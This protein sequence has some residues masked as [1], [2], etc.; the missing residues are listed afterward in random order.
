MNKR[1]ARN[2]MT[3]KYGITGFVDL[4]G[5]VAKKYSLFDETYWL[6]E[7]AILLY[8]W[9]HK[10]SNIIKYDSCAF[11]K[12][13]RPG[14]EI[15]DFYFE[16]VFKKYKYTLSEFK[17]Y[18]DHTIIQILLDLLSAIA[19]LHENKITHRDVKPSN[20][21]IRVD[22]SGATRAILIDFSHAHRMVC[23]LKRIDADV[24]TYPYRA[25]EVFMY[26]RSEKNGMYDEKIDI[27][28]IGMLLIE[29]ITDRTLYTTVTDGEESSW[30]K[31]VT[32]DDYL[33]ILE[34][35]FM[36]N[37]RTFFHADEYWKW[38][39]KMLTKDPAKRISAREMYNEIIE[40]AI[41]NNIKHIIPVNEKYKQEEKE[42]DDKEG[43]E[44]RRGSLTSLV[45][46]KFMKEIHDFER[47]AK[48]AFYFKADTVRFDDVMQCLIRKKVCNVNNYRSIIVATLMIIDTV[49]Y[50][51][52]VHAS[53][54]ARKTGSTFI[55]LWNAMIQIIQTCDK[56]LFMN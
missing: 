15:P 37:K 10:L 40:F 31:L 53:E 28:A 51:R 49:Y 44:S 30:E 27:W 47:A 41:E 38:I 16:M 36:H 33:T 4:K 54:V 45:D 23:D 56:E 7:Y 14:T 50:D 5:P 17:V 3:T 11:T 1:M 43:T 46:E 2:T 13:A 9:R 42:K 29:L 19:F 32:K 24:V 8:L 26:K 48:Y 6:K 21:M 34:K 52:I 20:V 12:T 35:E 18:R 25:P 55:E 22:S 39:S